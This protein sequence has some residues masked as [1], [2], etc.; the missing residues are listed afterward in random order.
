MLRRS[1]LV[2]FLTVGKKTNREIYRRDEI[3]NLARTVHQAGF[4][5]YALRLEQ[6]EQ[7][8]RELEQQN[9]GLREAFRSL[10]QPGAVNPAPA[11]PRNTGSSNS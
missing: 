5:L 10:L 1:E 3:D 2:G 4:D 7:R 9:E 6:L 8:R 11:E